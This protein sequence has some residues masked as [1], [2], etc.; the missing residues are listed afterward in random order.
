MGATGWFLIVVAAI[1]VASVAYGMARRARGSIVLT[2][3]TSDFTPG[4]TIHG[5]VDV[6][7]KKPIEAER[8]VVTLTATEITETEKD[9]STDRTSKQ[10]LREER[11]LEQARSYAADARTSSEFDITVPKLAPTPD[12]PPVSGGASFAAM[13]AA[14]RSTTR[15]TWRLEARLAAKGID[16]VTSRPLTVESENR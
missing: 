12:V 15:R 3:P 14:P 13:K 7:A 2:L 1:V 4:E 5:Q 9:G 16:L 10:L 6:H 11:V 8:L